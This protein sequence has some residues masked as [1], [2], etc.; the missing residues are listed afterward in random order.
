MLECCYCG[1]SEGK[2]KKERGTLLA[3]EGK[4]ERLSTGV[5]S[6]MLGPKATQIKPLVH[7]F[8]RE[9]LGSC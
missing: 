6:V 9:L 2:K 3:F 1:G 7:H 8:R 5:R 4:V